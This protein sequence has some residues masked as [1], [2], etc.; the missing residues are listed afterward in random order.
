MNRAVSVKKAVLM[1][2]RSLKIKRNH[3]L[4]NREG[5][6]KKKP[7]R[8]K[9]KRLLIMMIEGIKGKNLKMIEIKD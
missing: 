9:I 7:K 8:P 3:H 2:K 4:R 1:K 5:M 6:I